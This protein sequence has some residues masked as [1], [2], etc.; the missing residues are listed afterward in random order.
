M[1]NFDAKIKQVKGQNKPIL[2]AFEKWLEEKGL[3]K[4]TIYNHVVNVDWFAE[5]RGLKSLIEVDSDDFY[6][7]CA[8]FFPRKVTWASANSARANMASFRKFAAFMVEA[9][10]WDKEREQEIRK[11]LKENKDKF[12]ETA[13]SYYGQYDDDVW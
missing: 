12:I 4:K 2:E 1:L 3:S 13:E 6:M 7:Y 11:T 10:Y 5:S 9:E 8:D